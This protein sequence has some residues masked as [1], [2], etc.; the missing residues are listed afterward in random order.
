MEKNSKE[1]VELKYVL[2]GNTI[3]SMHQIDRTI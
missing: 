2:T 3:D 1:T